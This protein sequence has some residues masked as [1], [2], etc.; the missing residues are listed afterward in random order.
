MPLS[1][2]EINEIYEEIVSGRQAAK[3][4]AVR[5]MANPKLPDIVP[6]IVYRDQLGEAISV[7][8][9]ENTDRDVYVR[10]HGESWRE[11][12]FSPASNDPLSAFAAPGVVEEAV[13]TVDVAEAILLLSGTDSK[14]LVRAGVKRAFDA[15]NHA[16]GRIS[17]DAL[18]KRYIA[19]R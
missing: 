17:V 6:E 19:G 2:E 10:R 15:L 14:E 7:P 3:V 9:K 12:S 13:R 5:P 16:G 8:V 11:V 18:V 4:D 1:N